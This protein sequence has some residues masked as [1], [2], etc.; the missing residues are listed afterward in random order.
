MKGYVRCGVLS[1]EWGGLKT[2]NSGGGVLLSLVVCAAT[3]AGVDT[4]AGEGVDVV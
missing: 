3:N 2:R 1:T 4:V